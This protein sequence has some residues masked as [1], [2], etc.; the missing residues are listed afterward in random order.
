MKHFQ[1]T[2]AWICTGITS[3]MAYSFLMSCQ[4]VL[5]QG[6]MAM[7]DAKFPP[8]PKKNTSGHDKLGEAI[9]R[10]TEVWTVTSH[11][12]C[13]VTGL[14][15]E[16]DLYMVFLINFYWHADTWYW[17]SNVQCSS[18]KHLWYIVVHFRGVQF[19]RG[20]FVWV[21]W[22][23][24]QIMRFPKN[25]RFR[26]LFVWVYWTQTSNYGLSKKSQI[27]VLAKHLDLWFFRNS[28]F[29]QVQQAQDEMGGGAPRSRKATKHSWAV[30]HNAPTSQLFP[31]PHFFL[32]SL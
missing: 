25:L 28:A 3:M 19:F 1:G 32:Q 26:G 23:K 16:A 8:P 20:F 30:G 22:T 29:F 6:W 17:R 21:Y 2:P 31:P 27:P 13:Q 14:G 15:L 11:H 10:R 7:Q 5:R 18:K 9:A 24:P 4:A 12:A